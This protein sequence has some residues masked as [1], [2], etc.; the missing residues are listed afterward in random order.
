M[1][2]PL[3]I[4]FA[5]LGLIVVAWTAP[6][7]AA[8]LGEPVSG[9]AVL[10]EINAARA[11]PAAYAEGLRRYRAYYD[12]HLV[13][14]PGDDVGVL[15]VEGGAAIDDAIAYVERQNP[16]PPLEASA[17]LDEAAARLADDLGPAGRVGHQGADGASLS[18]RLRAVGVW[19]GA[20]AEDV[21]FGQDTA[22]AVVRQLIIDDGVPS[23]GHRSVIF[24]PG[25][26]IAG[27]GCGP[28]R[29]YGHMCVIDFAGAVMIR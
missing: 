13:R 25:M 29:L 2:S 8:S 15:T 18:D 5:L 26:R 22:A 23:R 24:D 4:V 27:V 19:A 6:A 17:R 1:T 20:S 7:S 10:A 16:A 9:E 12:G 11:D 28:H 21:S 14:E 3:A